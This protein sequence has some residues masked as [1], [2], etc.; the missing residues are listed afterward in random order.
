[1]ADAKREGKTATTSGFAA[2]KKAQKTSP[3]F[4]GGVHKGWSAEPRSEPEPVCEKRD[5]L[6]VSERRE[7]EC[8]RVDGDI[9]GERTERVV[10]L[11]E[12]AR[13]LR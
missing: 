6:E 4:F 12:D 8:Q 1:V 2:T 9:G 10:E 5:K 11:V 3:N 7:S 13:H